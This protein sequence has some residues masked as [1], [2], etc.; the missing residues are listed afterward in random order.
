MYQCGRTSCSHW[1]DQID[2]PMPEPNHHHMSRMKLR[3]RSTDSQHSQTTY[4]ATCRSLVRPVFP[5]TLCVMPPYSCRGRFMQDAQASCM[6]QLM[7]PYPILQDQA[8]TSIKL[9]KQHHASH[10]T[11]FKPA[12]AESTAQ[13]CKH[14]S[15]TNCM[16]SR[17]S[18]APH[19]HAVR[20][21]GRVWV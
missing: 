19:M 8:C 5:G 4:K 6:L 11:P 2:T 7:L 14:T 20:D 21:K 15:M 13:Q 9:T 3:H 1:P 17:K 16:G 12:S 18:P 10:F